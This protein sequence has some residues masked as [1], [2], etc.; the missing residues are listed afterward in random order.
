VYIPH[1]GEAV[2]FSSQARY[3]RYNRPQEIADPKAFEPTSAP[4]PP[5]RLKS[6]RSVAHLQVKEGK[7]TLEFPPDIDAAHLFP[8]GLYRVS[9]KMGSITRAELTEVYKP[10]SGTPQS[11]TPQSG[12]PQS[13]DMDGEDTLAP[14]LDQGK[15]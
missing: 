13:G 3:G 15:G 4:P 11:G 9:I 1:N 8:D 2:E 10:Q 12:T 6:F 14:D 5:S 7:V